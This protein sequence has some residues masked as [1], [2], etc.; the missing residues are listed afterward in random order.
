[1]RL[2]PKGL[3]P[4]PIRGGGAWHGGIPVSAEVSAVSVCPASV[5]VSIII[6]VT[7]AFRGF[8]R[9]MFIVPLA[10]DE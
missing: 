8:P 2:H 5:L 4:I 3:A 7:P 9:E 1:M 10:E 6:S